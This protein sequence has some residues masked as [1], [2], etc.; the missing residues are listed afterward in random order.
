[1]NECLIV[2]LF[3]SVCVGEFVLC[4]FCFQ[5][6]GTRLGRPFVFQTGKKFRYLLVVCGMICQEN[7]IFLNQTIVAS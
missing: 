7:M 5:H 4:Y 6:V 2:C 1:M 3:L